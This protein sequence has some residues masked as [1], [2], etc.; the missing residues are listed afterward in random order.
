MY[1]INIF[2]RV[3]SSAAYILFYSALD[4]TKLIPLGKKGTKTGYCY[5][6]IYV[7]YTFK[8]APILDN[9]FLR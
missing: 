8:I 1:I 3:E 5:T 2:S 4:N 6:N 7:Q 9:S